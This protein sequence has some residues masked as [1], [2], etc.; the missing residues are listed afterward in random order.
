MYNVH[1]V[2]HFEISSVTFFN[3]DLSWSIVLVLKGTT[4]TIFLSKLLS[5]KMNL[6]IVV[7][8]RTIYN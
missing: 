7:E 4:E 6:E 1:H 5:K 8:S 3:L 2:L